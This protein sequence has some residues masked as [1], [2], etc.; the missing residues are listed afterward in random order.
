M[1]IIINLLKFAEYKGIYFAIFEFTHKLSKIC[2]YILCLSELTDRYQTETYNTKDYS[3]K[4]S[5]VS[6]YSW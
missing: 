4:L 6:N 1:D 2:H 5:I 3:I